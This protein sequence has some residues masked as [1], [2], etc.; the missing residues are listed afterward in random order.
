ML[1]SHELQPG[2]IITHSNHLEQLRDL[3]VQWTKINPLHALENEII[4]VQSNGITQWLKL[5]LAADDGCAIAAGLDVGLPARF[6]WQIY[7]KVL[8]SDTIAHSSPFDKDPLTWRLMR[9]LPSVMEQPVFAPLQHFL[10][11]DADLRKRYQLAERLADLFD[12]YQVYRSDWLTDWAA[13]IDQLRQLEGQPAI[14]TQKAEGREHTI[15]WQAALWRL[16]IADIGAEAVHSSR[17]AVHP[18]FIAAMKNLEH[19]PEIGRASCRER[20]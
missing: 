17:A 14:S 9:L 19:T 18:R 8:G 7:R 4:L 2:F 11:D 12:Q 5:A 15:A 10:S 20:V 6:L 3:V 13:G 16:L 1:G